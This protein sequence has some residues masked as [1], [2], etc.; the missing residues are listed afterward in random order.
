M[1]TSF[2]K[3]KIIQSSLS[4]YDNYCV[5][6]SGKGGYITALILAIDSFRKRF[7]RPGSKILDSIMA[8]D[9]AEVTDT[10]IGQINMEIVSSFIGSQGL[11]W[12]YDL[13]KEEKLKIPSMLNK[14]I[15]KKFRG[16][17][18]K[19]GENL[20]R[21]GKMLFG[22]R[23]KRHF[24]LLP[25]T[26]V[27]C[28]GKF[29]F[30]EGPVYLYAAASIGVPENRE[31]SACILMEDVGKLKKVTPQ[32]KQRILLN[33]IQSVL[34]IGKN[35]KI[36]YREIFVDLVIKKINSNEMGCALIAIPYFHLAKKALHKNLA[37]QTLTEWERGAKSYFL[38][39]Q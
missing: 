25:G 13:A 38:S 14:N 12:G 16:I 21:A 5:G 10:Y 7:S 22:G 1:K 29:H 11:I 28:A 6:F 19:N 8:Y 27:P 3:D 35:H 26:H 4:P 37:Q 17:E 23:D 32:V 15:L 18:I 30:E 2:L 34:E 24:P 20:R 31:K 36:N 39:N 33:G 9:R